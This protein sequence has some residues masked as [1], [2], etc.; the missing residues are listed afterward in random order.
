MAPL[1]T[2]SGPAI[3]GEPAPHC[4]AH[5]TGMMTEGKE[6][7]KEG[8]SF[9]SS[10]PQTPETHLLQQVPPRVVPPPNPKSVYK[11]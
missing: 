11:L 6:Q 3:N 7:N 10:K 1:S 5:V 9:C 4:R 2:A 8:N